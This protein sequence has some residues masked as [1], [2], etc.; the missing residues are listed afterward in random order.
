MGIPLTPSNLEII[1]YRTANVW[2]DKRMIINQQRI[3]IY[4]SFVSLLAHF[5]KRN[6]N[7]KLK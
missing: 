3:E 4:L 7:N 2:K 6:A 5:M 1:D